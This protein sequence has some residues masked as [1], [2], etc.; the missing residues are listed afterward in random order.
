M[1][2]CYTCCPCSAAILCIRGSISPALAGLCLVYALDLTR[3]L[4][5]GTAMASK[6]ESD[7]NSVERVVQYLQPA[8]EAAEDTDP[9]VLE[10]MPKDWPAG[11]IAAAASVKSTSCRWCCSYMLRVRVVGRP[12]GKQ[13]SALIVVYTSVLQLVRSLCVI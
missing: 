3:Y 12:N 6:T 9:E 8:T 4:K 11:R 10:T 2:H 1:L 7:F 13:L 5:H